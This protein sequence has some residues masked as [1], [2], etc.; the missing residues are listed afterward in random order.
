MNWIDQVHTASASVET[1]IRRVEPDGWCE[2]CGTAW[3]NQDLLGHLAAWSDFLIDEVEALHG[4]RVG[5]IETVDVDSW[6]AAQIERRRGR[7]AD[8]TVDEW[9]RAVQRVIEVVG[10]LP[11]DAWNRDW[12]VAWAAEPVSIDDLLRL[13]LG[14]IGQ[15]RSRLAGN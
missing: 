4:D 5:T 3:S 13:W 8:E 2:P 12:R 7:T 15:H 11:A 6:N 1:W 9:R 10:G 14:H